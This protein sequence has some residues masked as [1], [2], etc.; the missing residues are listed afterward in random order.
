MGFWDNQSNTLLFFKS[1]VKHFVLLSLKGKGHLASMPDK[2][3]AQRLGIKWMQIHTQIIS[4]FSSTPPGSAQESKNI[5]SLDIIHLSGSKELFLIS[6]PLF[7]LRFCRSPPTPPAIFI[8]TSLSFPGLIASRIQPTFCRRKNMFVKI[9]LQTG[10]R[11][12]GEKKK[13]KDKRTEEKMEERTI[14]QV[15]FTNTDKFWLE[16]QILWALFAIPIQLNDMLRKLSP[17]IL[18]WL[19]KSAFHYE[20]KL[21]FFLYPDVLLCIWLYQ[22]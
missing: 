7:S 19:P 12:G 13:K 1:Y 16:E 9:S 5:P 21:Y 8:L 20:S 10:T 17:T 2:I 3:S 18:Q 6:L 14:F 15:L 4:I 11:V 22:N